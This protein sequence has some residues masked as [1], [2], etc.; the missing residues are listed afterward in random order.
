MCVLN[1][2]VQIILG[3]DISFNL[4]TRGLGQFLNVATDYAVR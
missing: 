3:F 4:N 1:C 2:D